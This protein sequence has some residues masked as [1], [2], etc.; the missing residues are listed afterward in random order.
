MPT[1]P[2]EDTV[3]FDDF[4]ERYV[5]FNALRDRLVPAIVDWLRAQLPGGGRAVD[6][7]C[8]EGRH[9][10]L[11]ADRYREV[12]AVDVSPQMLRLARAERARPHVRYEQRGVRDVTPGQDGVFD[13]VLSV[14]VLHHV[15]PLETVLPHL[16]RLV[17][18]GGRLVLADIVAGPG[19]GD[20]DWHLEQAFQ[21]A[22]GFYQLSDGDPDVAADVLRLT[23]HPRWLAMMVADIPPSRELFHRHVDAAFPGAVFDD[24]LHP[25]MGAASWQ[26]R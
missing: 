5:R 14:N 1:L 13:A 6:L 24:E 4:A 8:G 19:W 2:D 3:Y 20:P 17:A 10:T 12:L 23:L 7:G 26:A 25:A 11:L 21:A 22:R 18:P 16:R 9:T 15:G